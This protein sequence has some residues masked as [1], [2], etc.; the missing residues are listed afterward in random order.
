MSGWPCGR[1]N[2]PNICFGGEILVLPARTPL[3]APQSHIKLSYSL[4]SW[5]KNKL[6]GIGRKKCFTFKMFPNWCSLFHFRE[7]LVSF[8]SSFSNYFLCKHQCLFLYV[9]FIYGRLCMN[10]K[11]Q[12]NPC[13]SHRAHALLIFLA[14]CSWQMKAN[15][16]FL[17][18]LFLFQVL[19][20]KLLDQTSDSHKFETVL[21]NPST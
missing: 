14:N 5:K 4:P 2:R 15:C 9:F 19:E 18:T 21:L 16:R 11:A 8:P 7:Q 10:D 6:P 12:N 1:R 3:T 20:V 17:F 13:C